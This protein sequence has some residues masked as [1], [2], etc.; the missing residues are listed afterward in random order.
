[1]NTS[2][3]MSVIHR[4]S[5]GELQTVGLSSGHLLG[6]RDK[7]ILQRLEEQRAER[8]RIEARL[9]QKDAHSRA[10]RWT[11][12]LDIALAGTALVVLSP[13]FLMLMLLVRLTSRGPI[14]FRQMRAGLRGQP[15][16]IYKFRTMVVDAEH[17]KR[18]LLSQN[19][20][21]GGV[22]FKMKSDPRVTWVGR[23]MRRWSLDELPQLWNV[24]RG[25]MSLVGP[26]PHP[27]TEVKQYP[28]FAHARLRV[29]PGLTGY[30]Q[31]NGRSD[32]SFRETVDWDIRYVN[33][34][35][36]RDYVLLLWKTIRVVISGRGAY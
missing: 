33:Q 2:G 35:S 14:F 17:K 28:L 8:L 4:C 16:M 29:K 25:E 5:T 36:V 21:K 34:R 23:W 6:L 19:E 20:Q 13:L 31:V 1:M 27:L 22:I 18:A 26:R 15:F 10:D 9:R 12:L 11:R 24:L 7:S 30:A 32:L 3:Q